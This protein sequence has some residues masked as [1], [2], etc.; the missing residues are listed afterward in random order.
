[1]PGAPRHPL[2]EGGRIEVALIGTGSP[3]EGRADRYSQGVL[4]PP[5]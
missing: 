5:W 4:S 2:S 1:M 3:R